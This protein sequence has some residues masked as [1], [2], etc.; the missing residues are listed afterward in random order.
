L[1]SS[2]FT[3]SWGFGGV[4]SFEII[5][6]RSGIVIFEV[7]GPKVKEVFA[8]EAGGHRWQRVPPT[9]KRGRVQTSTITVAVLPE[10]TEAQVHIS[11]SDIECQMI[12]GS[13]SG[14]Q[15]RN[16]TS[17]CC[18]IKHKPS[19]LFVRCE[20][21]RSLTQNKASAMALLRARLWEQQNN[22]LIGA[23]DSQRR[24]QVG[25]GMRGDKR[26]T[27]RLDGVH[28]HISGK[29]WEYKSYVKGEW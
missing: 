9:E 26:R 19:G 21:E 11:E 23:R 20:T 27:I 6:Q 29:S 18:L 10:P 5:E 13:G 3:L 24:Q 7:S 16:K 4:F 15:K 12:R 14:G 28:D 25:S 2:P 8:N 22:A 1:N 17:N